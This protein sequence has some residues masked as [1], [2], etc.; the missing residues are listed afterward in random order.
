MGNG[1][2]CVQ[3][4]PENSGSVADGCVPRTLEN[5]GS[6]AEGPIRM[7]T[8]EVCSS[9]RENRVDPSPSPPDPPTYGGRRLTDVEPD[10]GPMVG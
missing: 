5:S 2:Y 4:T 8:L 7:M 9:L 6:G 10:T 1:G 3:R